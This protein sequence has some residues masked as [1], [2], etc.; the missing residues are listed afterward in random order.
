MAKLGHWQDPVRQDFPPVQVFP[1][2][3]Q[4]EPSVCRL[5]HAPPQLLVPGAQFASHA[6]LLH[7]S[8]PTHFFEHMP[9]LL[10]SDPV[11]MQVPLPQSVLPAGHT[12]PPLQTLPPVQVT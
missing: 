12:H 1:H 6:P 10:G 4:L 7:T 3:P 11:S 8:T 9:Q 2:I 5:T